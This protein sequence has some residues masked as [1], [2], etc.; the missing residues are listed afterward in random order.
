MDVHSI[1]NVHTQDTVEK[2]LEYA[3]SQLTPF[4]RT[5]TRRLSLLQ[6]LFIIGVLLFPCS[7]SFSKNFFA[8]PLQCSKLSSKPVNYAEIGP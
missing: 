7:S 2:Y 8:K 5:V 1:V 4:H 3:R 6:F